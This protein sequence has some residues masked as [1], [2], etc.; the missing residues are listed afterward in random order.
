MA[1][2]D[3]FL[4]IDHLTK[5]FEQKDRDEIITVIDDVSMT[6][7]EGEFV[8]FLGPSGC[9]KT[10]LIHAVPEILKFV[11]KSNIAFVFYERKS[12]MFPKEQPSD[13][14]DDV[15][16]LLQYFPG[17]SYRLVLPMMNMCMFFIRLTEMQ[18]PILT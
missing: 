18:I 16:C 5:R 10:T 11:T 14:E 8:V 9:G 2:Y 4:R 12:F 15:A 6:I 1:D 7:E 13:F 3:H 17:K